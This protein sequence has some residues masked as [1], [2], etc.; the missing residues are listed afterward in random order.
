[1][2]S[3]ES[4]AHEAE[5]AEADPLAHGWDLTPAQ[6]VAVQKR[7]AAQV[8]TTDD[9]D[10]SAVRIVAGVDVSL[11]EAGQAAIALLSY[12]ALETIGGV[13][14]SAPIT[15]PYVPGLLSFR[16]TPLVM[17]AWEALLAQGLPR[18][19]LLLVDGQGIAHPRRFGIACHVGLLTDTPAV[20]VAKSVLSGAFAPLGDEPGAQSPLVHRGEVVGMALRAKARTNPLIVSVGHRISLA[21][22]VGVVQSCLQGYRLPEPTRRAHLLSG[23]KP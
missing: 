23:S 20:G 19:D 18:P 17:R 4:V 13:T 16:E 10:L 15:F 12:P 5:T 21:T 3:D 14:A 9:F 1:M 22:A 8:R 11:K 7:L 6:A 2:T